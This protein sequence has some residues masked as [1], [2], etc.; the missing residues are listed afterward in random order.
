MTPAEAGV[1]LD[2][3]V[4]AF[5]RS[6]MSAETAQI[7]ARFMIDIPADVGANAV[8]RWI[9]RGRTFPLIADLREACEQ[10]DGSGPPDAD[11]AFAEVM[12]AVGRWGIYG[13]PKWS[14][15][16][17]GQAVDSITWREVC[18]SEH[19]PSLR[20]HFTKAYEAA[21]KRTADPKHA[22][23]VAGIVAEVKQKL[24]GSKATPALP[25]G[26]VKP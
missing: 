14:H 22:Q 16:A 7:Y 18:M 20:A 9:A 2:A 24:V 11:R 15:P 5:P 10:H 25:A 13:E 12:R 19:A 23:L 17:I 3:L 6:N 26:K 1:L 4:A 8:A 21:R